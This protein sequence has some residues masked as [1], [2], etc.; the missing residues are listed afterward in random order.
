VF[1]P[2]STIFQLYHGDQFYW[3]RK[4][5]YA[6]KTTDLLQV[7]VK[8]YHLMYRVHLAMGGIRTHNY[9]DNKQW[10]RSNSNYHMF[11]T[12]TAIISNNICTMYINMNVRYFEFYKYS[13]MELSYCLLP[14]FT[15]LNNIF[16]SI[17]RGNSS[18]QRNATTCQNMLSS[19]IT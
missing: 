11:T 8:L 10:L 1:N 17:E 5:E 2:H 6:E 15:L 19:L 3:W 9:S 7:T 13:K 14:L 18:T 4:P 16:S 12:T